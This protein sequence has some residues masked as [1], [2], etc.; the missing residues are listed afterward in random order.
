[1][2]NKY[3]IGITYGDPSGIGPEIL[4]STLN[5][6]SFN[7]KPTIF[8]NKTFLINLKQKIKDKLIYISNQSIDS[9][10]FDNNM[11]GYANSF[12]GKHSYACLRLAVDYILK[13]KIK[14]LVTGPVSKFAIN[15]AKMNFIGQTD[16]IAKMC[17]I[18]PSKVIML[19]AAND[20][21]IALYTRHIPLSLI[22]KEIT[23]KKLSDFLLNLNQEIKKWFKVKKPKIAVLGLNPH[24]GENGLIGNE[25]KSVII[26]AIKD[27]KK[28]G[29]SLYGPFSPDAFLAEAGKLYLKNKKQK[30]DVVVSMYHDQ[31]LPM[32]KAVCGFQGV[33]ITLGLPFLRVSPDHGTAFDIA[34]RNKASN[35]G[36]ASAVKFVEQILI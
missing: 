34:G 12:A 21:K 9:Y 32:F 7:L 4:S 33:N 36:M 28:R 30:Y 20:L 16:A 18:N 11:L 29:V 19:F 13:K 15:L 10:L 6:W 2:K 22:H 23:K 8:G 35:E 27:L 5:N 17:Q 1:M 26:P 3:S 14:A 24:A 31:S 25:E